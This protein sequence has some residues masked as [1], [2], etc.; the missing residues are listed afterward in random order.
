MTNRGLRLGVI[1]SCAILYCIGKNH[2]SMH[3]YLFVPLLNREI[4]LNSVRF[5]MMVALHLTLTLS[6][7]SPGAWY[8]Y[9]ALRPSNHPFP[10]KDLR[11]ILDNLKSQ[12]SGSHPRN[13]CPPSTQT[14]V[15]I[16]YFAYPGTSPAAQE[17][18]SN[19]L[20]SSM[21]NGR[22]SH[23]LSANPSVAFYTH[24]LDEVDS[25]DMDVLDFV[26]KLTA[27]LP[28]PPGGERNRPL[29]VLIYHDPAKDSKERNTTQTVSGVA[30]SSRMLL[31]FA[32]TETPD[33][34]EISKKV[35]T[36][37]LSY[38]LGDDA[39]RTSEAS[40]AEETRK[41]CF[42]EA[43]T[44]LEQT[45]SSMKSSLVLGRIAVTP[46]VAQAAEDII[47]AVKNKKEGID[48]K[49]RWQDEVTY[50]KSVQRAVRALSEHSDLG[51]KSIMPREHA[52]ALLLPLGLP[53]FL[54]IVQAA[55]KERKG[56]AAAAAAKKRE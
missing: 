30:L 49:N 53:I 9:D 18:I 19:N 29:T 33:W 11:N 4:R 28:T 8:A 45:L 7:R 13:S 27:K 40:L 26:G 56:A 5:V 39:V 55:M 36:W 17:L 42:A 15:S 12:S 2:C 14:P 51:R 16:E 48:A 22:A 23:F 24:K 35:D 41:T 52:V 46:S 38:Q 37:M 10:E 20:K 25:K 47:G 50:G 34:M 21:K 1:A 3:F 6:T 54:A 31:L 32:V 43:A 44:L